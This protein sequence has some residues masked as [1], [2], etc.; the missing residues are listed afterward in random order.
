MR[1]KL[2]VLQTV[3]GYSAFREGQAEAVDTVLSGRD[4]LSVMPTGA[5]KSLCFQLPGLCMDGVTLVIS[6]L[7]SLMQDQV[8]SLLQTGVRAAYLNS[9]LT[10]RQFD[11]ALENAR[12]G[13]YKIIYVSPERL[14]TPRFLSFARS[15]D[16]ALIAVDEAHCVSQ[17]GQDFRPSYLK[18]PTFLE[19]LD[20]R[21]AVGAYTATATPEVRRD[22]VDKLGLRDPE[23]L[24]SGFDRTNLFWEVRQPGDK[25]AEL[26]KRIRAQQ[27]RSGIV[28]CATRK[29][30]EEVCRLLC[31]QGIAATRYHAGLAEEERRQNQEDFVYDRKQVMVATNAFGM[32]IDK[33]DVRFVIHYNMPKDLESY[34]QE[35][36]RAGRDGEQAECLLLY[37]GKDVYTNLFLIEHGEVPEGVDPETAAQVVER[38]KARLRTMSAYCQGTGCLRNYI[39]NYFGESR[40]VPCG[41]CWNC[42]HTFQRQDI[43]AEAREILLCVRET[44]E[45]FGASTIAQILQG[46]DTDRVRDWRLYRHAAYG[47]LSSLT[48]SGIRDRIRYLEENGFL[49]RQGGQYPTLSL[50]D[51]AE[52]LLDRREELSMPVAEKPRPEKKR[53]YA[54]P[55]E[56]LTGDEKLFEALRSVRSGLARSRGV[57]PYVI[58][59][60]RTLH[61]MCAKRPA[62]LAELREVSGVGTQKLERYGQA[63]L[64]AIQDYEANL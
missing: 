15:A 31:G 6:P 21:P 60:D 13:V 34:Y 39:L 41:K 33:S 36:G 10:P 28:Y 20:S 49:E 25:R 35:A 56:L 37:S 48:Q 12:R 3:Y 24:V 9:S 29:N 1:D 55:E 17:W 16:I 22:I 7:I 2:E 53:S 30:V 27:G 61:D 38:E 19:A 18:I 45:R 43:T 46:A 57:P 40:T 44:G 11:L 62:S 50:G 32:G 26:L 47:A 63:F 58:F 54:R 14:E 4:L 23:V 5:G 59:S 64:K 51:R 8:A 52:Q 42:T